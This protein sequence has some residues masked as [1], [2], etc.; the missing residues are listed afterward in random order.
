MTRFKDEDDLAADGRG[1]EGRQGHPCEPRLLTNDPH[2]D[3]LAYTLEGT[4]AASFEIFSTDGQ[5][6][7]KSGVTRDRDVKS[8]D[9][10][11]VEGDHGNGGGD[12]NAITTIAI[13]V[14]EMPSTHPA[15]TFA[16]VSDPHRPGLGDRQFRWVENTQRGT[17]MMLMARPRPA[18][19]LV[20]VAA[21]FL[22]GTGAPSQ[23][24][25]A[26]SPP[27]PLD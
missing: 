4:D 2:S 20:A 12:T 18:I 15:P 27:G 19:L 24:R 14:D 8:G 3:P 16:D 13:D 25:M 22:S 23:R 17:P 1:A 5:T 9:A 7:T 6:G 11:S 10:M 21:L 26:P